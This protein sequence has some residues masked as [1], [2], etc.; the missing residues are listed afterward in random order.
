MRIL[1]LPFLAWAVVP[2]VAGAQPATLHPAFPVLDDAGKPWVETHAEPSSDRTCGACHD[3]A[4][5]DRTDSHRRAGHK[6]PC[7][8]CHLAGSRFPS[9]PA[10]YDPQGRIRAESLRPSAPTNAHCASC[11]GIVHSGPEP[12]SIPDDFEAVSTGPAGDRTYWITFGTG[13]VLSPQDVS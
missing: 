8:Q 4:F 11:H 12:V 5:V 1:F 7:V 6:A 13:E 10:A 2:L 9:D 3:A